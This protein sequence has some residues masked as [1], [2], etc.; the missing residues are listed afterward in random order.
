MPD[1]TSQGIAFPLPGDLIRNPSGV[2]QLAADMETLARTADDAIRASADLVLKSTWVR[3][4]SVPPGDVSTWVGIDLAGVYRVPTQVFVDPIP[5]RPDGAGPGYVTI[6]PIGSTASV[7]EWAEFDGLRRTWKRTVGVGETGWTPV[8]ALRRAGVAL[9]AGQGPDTRVATDVGHALP[10]SLGVRVPRW[11]VHFRNTNDRVNGTI[12]GALNVVGVSVGRM[13]R[14]ADGL[15]SQNFEPGTGKVIQFAT[16][17]PASG[18]ELV[19]D[20]VEDYPLEPHTDYVLRYGFTGVAGQQVQYLQGGGW[21]ITNGSASVHSA[22]VEATQVKE[23]PLDVWVEVEVPQDTP[24]WAYY[25]DSLTVGRSA[26]LP[27][28]DGWPAKHARA[29]GAIPTLYAHSGSVMSEWTD[30]LARRVVKYVTGLYLIDR[31]DRLYWSMGSNDIFAGAATVQQMRDR[32]AAAWPVIT[33]VTSTNV[34]FT[35]ILP[36]HD[37]AHPQETVRQEWNRIL[38]DE[39]PMGALMTLDAA[40]AI[41]APSGDRLDTRWS[42]STTDIHLNTAGY[43]RFAAAVGSSVPPV[44]QGPDA[45][46]AYLAEIGA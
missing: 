46:A 27:V 20:W 38:Q 30:P 25:G 17:T 23:S 13:V 37:P 11:R 40:A 18:S 6:T 15:P 29:H 19:T 43:A 5:G 36:R 9:T 4:G 39:L 2:A 33:S 24:V 42:A 34:I 31:A 41:A 32:L 45:L 16:T 12:S 35:T 7:I 44:S 3:A 8:Q 14:T 28:F 26:A 10:M 22:S 21:S 1:S